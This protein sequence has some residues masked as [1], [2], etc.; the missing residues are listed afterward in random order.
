MVSVLTAIFAEGFI[1]GKLL[2]AVGLVPVLCFAVVT[3]LLYS[4]FKDTNK[5]VALTAA[6]FN[7]VGL[8]FE[9][10]EW[11]IP[12]VNAALVF[13]G[14]YCLLIGYL[15]FRSGFLSRISGLL[16]ALGGVAWLVASQAARFPQSLHTYAQAAGFAG[17]G[18]L[19][20]WLLVLGVDV[21]KR[22]AN[23]SEVRPQPPHPV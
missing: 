18:V 7:L 22:V 12:G 11:D 2:Y 20:L 9:A 17:E 14:I 6:C 16:M 13:H 10:F 3:L 4:I 8:V 5:S 1:R 19:M 23:G 21:Q 15:V